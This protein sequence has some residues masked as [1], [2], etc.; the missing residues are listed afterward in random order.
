VAHIWL[1]EPLYSL[2]KR[3]SWSL[4]DQ[5]YQ[6]LREISKSEDSRELFYVLTAQM[7]Q[8]NG[9]VEPFYSIEYPFRE[10]GRLQE[11][12]EVLATAAGDPPK[13]CAES[14]AG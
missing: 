8:A 3:Q 6:Q 1:P 2:S 7:R 4:R 9:K 11:L 14:T 10:A 13:Y 12:L 5:R